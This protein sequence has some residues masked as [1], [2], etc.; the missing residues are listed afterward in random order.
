MSSSVA[1]MCHPGL[2]GG[3]VRS[4]QAPPSKRICRPAS[5]VSLST[6][7][8]ISESRVRNSCLRSGMV[9]LS[10]SKTARRSAPACSSHAASS[11]VSDTGLR[12]RCSASAT[13]ARAT[14][15]RRVSHSLSRPRATSRFSGSTSVKL[16]SRALGLIPGALDRRLERAQ[17]SLDARPRRAPARRLSPAGWPARAR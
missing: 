15:A 9:V 4:T 5:L 2:G 13:S 7:T 16:A 8:V 1:G 11:S 12:A 10:A 3:T 17:A 14:S 6:V